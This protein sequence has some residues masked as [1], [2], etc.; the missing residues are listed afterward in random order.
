MN[1]TCWNKQLHPGATNNCNSLGQFRIKASLLKQPTW[2]ACTSC[3]SWSP[4]SSCGGLEWRSSN[5]DGF[6]SKSINSRRCKDI[7][8]CWCARWQ[9]WKKRH[10][11][12]SKIPDGLLSGIVSSFK[13]PLRFAKLA[14]FILV[15]IKYG[16]LPLFPCNTDW[17]LYSSAKGSCELKVADM[18]C[19]WPVDGILSHS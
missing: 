19:R 15:L 1:P 18:W 9:Y 11:P 10:I 13:Y 5:S 7:Q 17:A 4:S 12:S 6:S 14:M 3:N 8:R 16:Y 2:E